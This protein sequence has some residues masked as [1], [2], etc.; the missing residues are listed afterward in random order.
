MLLTTRHGSSHSRALSSRPACNI[1]WDLVT[2]KN[3]NIKN[4][5][6]NPHVVRMLEL[7]WANSP[8]TP[9][10]HLPTPAQQKLFR[11]GTCRL[12]PGDPCSLLIF[13][14]FLL[15]P[16]ISTSNKAKL[17]SLD[18]LNDIIKL[19]FLSLPLFWSISQPG[20]LSRASSLFSLSKGSSPAESR[21]PWFLTTL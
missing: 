15:S 5:N 9:P 7:F 8:P 20:L 1:Q 19:S 16:P 3:I 18:P 2:N 4:R 12:S 13:W 21:K 10:T 14:P 6:Y 17:G 11:S